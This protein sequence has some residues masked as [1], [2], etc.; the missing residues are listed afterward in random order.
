MIVSWLRRR[1]AFAT[2]VEAKTY[3]DLLV[4]NVDYPNQFKQS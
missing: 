3:I 2:Y 4:F 1:I